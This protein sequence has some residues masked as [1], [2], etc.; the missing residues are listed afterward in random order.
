MSSS[1]A[2][3]V[4]KNGLRS[5]FFLLSK[6]L[7]ER[8]AGGLLRLAKQLPPSPLSTEKKSILSKTELFKKKHAGQRGFVIGTG[9]SIQTQDLRPLANEITFSLSGFWQHTIVREW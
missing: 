7:L 8:T 1:L 2:S 9:P 3:V 5:S 6:R 4:K